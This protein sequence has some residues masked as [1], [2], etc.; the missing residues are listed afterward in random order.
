MTTKLFLNQSNRPWILAKTLLALGLV[1]IA[2]GC[3]VNQPH[4]FDSTVSTHGTNAEADWIQLQPDLRVSP[5]L[6]IVELSATVCLDAGWLEQVVCGVGTREHESIMVTSVPASAVHAA[7]LSVGM[8]PGRPGAW[9][10]VDGEII[11]IQPSGGRVAVRV[12]QVGTDQWSP[13]E[14]W[15]QSASGQEIDGEWIFAGSSMRPVEETPPGYSRYEAD[16]SG[17]LIGLVTFGDELIGYGQVIPDRV[18]VAPPKWKVNDVNVPPIGSQILIRMRS[19][20]R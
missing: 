12:A 16:L 11:E 14:T 13:V 18:D 4:A 6:G 7:L 5:S 17:S 2:G 9:Q 20:D 10:E 3:A 15:I 8:S 1:Y 19:A